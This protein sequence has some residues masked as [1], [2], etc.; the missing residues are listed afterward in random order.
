MSKYCVL[1]EEEFNEYYHR[2]SN[3]EATISIV[4]GKFGDVVRAK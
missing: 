4:K 2:R 3:S 1:Y